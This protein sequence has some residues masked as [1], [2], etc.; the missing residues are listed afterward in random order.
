MSNDRHQGS[1]RGGGQPAVI[2][3]DG[4]AASGKGTLAKRLAAHFRYAHLDTG[5]LYRGVGVAVLRSGGDPSDAAAAERAARS[6]DAA[7]LDDA[8]LRTAE[9]GAAASKVAAHP[10]VRAALLALQRDF[11]RRP[12]GGAAGAVLDGR[13]IGTVICPDAP[14]KLFVTASVEARAERRLK[15]LQASGAA[16]IYAAV[17]QD[18]I[19]RDHRDSTRSAAPLKPAEDAIVLDTT[20]LDADA[21]FAA[22][23][24]A[25]TSRN[26]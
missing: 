7:G 5:K 23:I 22:A 19:E 13:D 11:A 1:A 20:H 14:T 12:P 4:P 10:G 21:T 16:A 2:A 25:M 24:A 26:T 18:L 9:A 8:R 15:E 6:L 17:L 3:I